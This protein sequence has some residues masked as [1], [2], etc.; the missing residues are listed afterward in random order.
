MGKWGSALYSYG[1][2]NRYVSFFIVS[3]E[4]NVILIQDTRAP[5]NMRR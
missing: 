1:Y 5:E 2:S 3:D 4:L